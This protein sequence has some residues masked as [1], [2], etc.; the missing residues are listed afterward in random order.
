MEFRVCDSCE[1]K[2]IRVP[3]TECPMCEEGTM[4][5]GDSLE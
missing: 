2:D 5:R 1:F 3:G 4:V